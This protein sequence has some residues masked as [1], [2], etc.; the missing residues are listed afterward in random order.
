MLRFNILAGLSIWACQVSHG[1]SRGQLEWE[2][3]ID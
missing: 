3:I 2:I 1:V